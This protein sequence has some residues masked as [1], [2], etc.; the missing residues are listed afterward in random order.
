M[1]S[2]GSEAEPGREKENHY[3]CCHRS[4][5]ALGGYLHNQLQSIGVGDADFPGNPKIR[6]T[7]GF[8]PGQKTAFRWAGGVDIEF[9]LAFEAMNGN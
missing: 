7:V 2:T 5:T 9:E 3:H 6:V 1:L 8:S 4:N